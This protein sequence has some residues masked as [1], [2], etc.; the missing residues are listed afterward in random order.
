[1]KARQP[2]VVKA[3]DP[4]ALEDL[5]GGVLLIGVLTSAAII[6]VGLLLLIPA[7]TGK[8]LLLEQLMS[9]HEVFIAELPTSLGSI[10]AGALRG[11]PMAII[12]LGLTLLIL[13]PILRVALS[14]VF[15]TLHRD[16][17]YALIS[18]TVLALLILGFVLGK[19]A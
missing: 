19:L 18:A 15:F 6:A 2:V 12:E 13:T 3:R 1:M 17:R 14:A 4:Y 5:V 7:G 16:R 8:R 10:L 9:E 11:R